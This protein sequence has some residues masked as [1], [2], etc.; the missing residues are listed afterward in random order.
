MYNVVLISV[1]QQTDSVMH[2]LFHIVSIIAYYR[3]DI[4]YSPLCYIVGFCCLSILFICNSSHLLIPN[5][6][7][8]LLPPYFHLTT[9]SLFSNCEA[10]FCFLAMFI[11]VIF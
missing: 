5:S 9:T 1:E 3:Q 10:V 2:I 4:G 6:Q 8:F 7:S 11:H